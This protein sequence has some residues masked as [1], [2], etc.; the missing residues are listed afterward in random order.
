MQIRPAEAG[1]HDGIETLLRL[2]FDGTEEARIVTA[3]REDDADTLELVAVK[4]GMIVGEIMFSPVTGCRKGAE[5]SFGLGLGPIAIAPA[6]QRQGIGSALMDAG[7][8]YVTAL[9]APWCILLGD[10]AYYSRF[11]FQIAADHGYTWNQDRTG[12]FAPYFQVR[13]LGASP[14]PAGPIQM[15][16][17]AAFNPQ[18][19]P[20][21]GT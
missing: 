13:A 12:Q 18:E 10:P 16:Y 2:A 19:T 20:E 17:H 8:D 11:G 1:D 9:G 7:L 14:L 3:L 4:N 21:S 15:H 5:I 6:H